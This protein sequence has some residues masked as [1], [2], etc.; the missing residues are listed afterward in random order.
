MR[1]DI[2]YRFK[3]HG[4]DNGKRCRKTNAEY[5]GKV[6]HRVSPLVKCMS[7]FQN[8]RFGNA[9]PNDFVYPAGIQQHD[10]QKDHG[11]PERQQQRGV[12]GAGVP[13]GQAGAGIG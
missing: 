1:I 8:R 12:A 10:G 6:P 7:V 5:P 2:A 9:T 11:N 3:P 4:V 13:Q